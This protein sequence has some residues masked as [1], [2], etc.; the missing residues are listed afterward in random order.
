MN[1]SLWPDNDDEASMINVP[2]KRVTAL[3]ATS[4]N[5]P[6]PEILLRFSTLQK[7]LRV[8]A[9]CHRWRRTA[10]HSP[11]TT[12]LPDE[13]DAALLRWLRIVQGVHYAAELAAARESRPTPHSSHLARLH[14]F[15]DDNGILR[16]GG[17]L[18]HAMLSYDERHPI[19]APPASWLTKL[20]IVL[21]SSDATRRHA[22]H[23]GFLRLRFWVPQGRTVVKQM[24][25]RCVTCIRWQAN[26]PQP[27]MGDLPR[28]RVTPA[29][30][31]LRTGVDYVDPIF[32]RTTKGRG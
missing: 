20:I 14:P 3:A 19:I 13:L 24:L 10:C 30:P 11:N 25:Y 16:V 17:R 28:G 4:K 27:L 22:A 5:R 18:K 32:I 15:I 21:P 1:S 7:L 6:E 23:S 2:E 29:R 31:F 26:T 12:L 9:W 8:S